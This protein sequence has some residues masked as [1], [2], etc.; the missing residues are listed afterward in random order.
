MELA[1]SQRR[2]SIKTPRGEFAALEATPT[3]ESIGT[4]LLIH[5]FTGSKEDFIHLLPELAKLGWRAVAIDQRGCYESAGTE[6]E[7]DYTMTE[8]ADDL[9]ELVNTFT[10]PVHLLGHS[11]G[12]LVTQATALTG[13]KLASLTLFC[14][15]PGAIPGTSYDW[16]KDFQ[17]DLRA[18]N[19]A[20]RIDTSITEMKA[21]GQIKSAEVEQF[22]RNR[23][24]GSKAAALLGKAQI[25]LEQA[26]LTT[27]LAQLTA[28][29]LPVLVTHGVDDDAWPISQQ[30]DMAEIIKAEYIVISNSAHSPNVENVAETTTVLDQFWRSQL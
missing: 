11:F 9:T 5:G 15:G 30:K 13:V 21:A 20:T 12:G 4:A 10:E 6:V 14:S 16:L 25:L 18:G 22:L 27:Q 19:K 8:F 2:F 23:W 29:G 28:A 26:E 1:A 17:A 24:S 7:A 3:G